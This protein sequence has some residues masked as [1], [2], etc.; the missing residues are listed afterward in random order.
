MLLTIL[1]SVQ[2]SCFQPEVDSLI[3]QGRIC[4]TDGNGIQST[5]VINFSRNS[6]AITDSAGYFSLRAIPGDSVVLFHIAFHDTSLV[7]PFSGNLVYLV[8]KEKKYRIPE[9]KIFPWG[10][11]YSD[12]KTAF[13]ALP[14][15]K[16]L[17][18]QLRLP[19]Q[20]DDAIPFWLDRER[21]SNPVLLLTS[22]I[23]YLYY[24]LNKKEKSALK[25]YELQKLKPQLAAYEEIYNR[26]NLMQITG[27]SDTAIDSFMVF[28]NI[29]KKNGPGSKEI[30]IVEEVKRCFEL[31]QQEGK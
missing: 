13:L 17:A 10:N 18:E 6:A 1:I 19:V 9:L 25:V 27:L 28:L 24:N 5:H 20:T 8:M 23:S 15:E 21:V 30:E 3:V 2:L 12:F 16:T 31:Y 26:N 29:R 14:L 7:W 4:R 11:S 22:P